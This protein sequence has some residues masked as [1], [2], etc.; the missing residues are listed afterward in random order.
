MSLGAGGGG[1][2]ERHLDI[3]HKTTNVFSS[4]GGG[5]GGGIQISNQFINYSYHLSTYNNSSNISVQD[6]LNDSSSDFWWNAGGGG[7]CG[8]CNK[9]SDKD[10]CRNDGDILCV[11]AVVVA[12][13]WTNAVY[14]NK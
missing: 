9:E 1:G 10:I 5:G 3:S 13:E 6:F 8:V 2:F 7:G 11:V 12:E 14:L 4:K